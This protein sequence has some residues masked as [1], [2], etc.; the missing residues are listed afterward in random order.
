MYVLMCMTFLVMN[1]APTAVSQGDI[2]AGTGKRKAETISSMSSS[3]VTLV[4]SGRTTR[5]IVST[6][7]SFTLLSHNDNS[8][9]VSYVTVNG[10]SDTDKEK[11]ENKDT[12]GSHVKTIMFVVFFVLIS[13]FAIVMFSIIILCFLYRPINNKRHINCL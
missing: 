12:P 2:V 1:G 9:D 3:T 5:E 10:T 8:T 11:D 6:T 7:A 13:L 4:A